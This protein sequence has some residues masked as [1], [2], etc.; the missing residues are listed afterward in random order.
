[1]GLVG[2]VAWPVGAARVPCAP[3][4][5]PRSST[6]THILACMHCIL[7]PS[8]TPSHP[9]HT[10]TRP[11]H[12]THTCTPPH[13]HAHTLACIIACSLV[14][15]PHAHIIADADPFD[16]DK[17]YYKDPAS[18]RLR[19]IRTTSQVENLNRR[20]NGLLQGPVS[21]ELSD[22]LSLEFCGRNNI[23]QAARAGCSLGLPAYDPLLASQLNACYPAGQKPYA[24]WDARRDVALRHRTERFGF[25]WQD[26]E[27]NQ[28]ILEGMQ[29]AQQQ[30]AEQAGQEGF[31]PQADLCVDDGEEEQYVV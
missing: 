14:T 30:A 4:A 17:M 22:D 31:T 19:S 9:T 16:I 11:S 20:Y 15:L 25:K 8:R 28:L 27:R 24:D 18:G 21:P 7:T 12:R 6:S 13:I 29:K 5:K 1:M 3:G 10:G 23:D 26:D 2:R